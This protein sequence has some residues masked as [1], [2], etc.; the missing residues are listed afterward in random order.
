MSLHEILHDHSNDY[1]KPQNLEVHH[2]TSGNPIKVFTRYIPG[3][4]QVYTILR[5]IPGIYLVYPGIYQ[6]Y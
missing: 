6:V 3:I 1:I 4:Y 2:V 5:Y